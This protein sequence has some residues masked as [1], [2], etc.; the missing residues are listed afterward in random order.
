MLKIENIQDIHGFGTPLCLRCVGVQSLK[1]YDFEANFTLKHSMDLFQQLPTYNFILVLYTIEMST[2]SSLILK[3]LPI[4][5]L[6]FASESSEI[7]SAKNVLSTEICLSC[8]NSVYFTIDLNSFINFL[9]KINFFFQN[10]WCGTA[11]LK[12][13]NSNLLKYW[14]SVATFSCYSHSFFSKSVDYSIQVSID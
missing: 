3:K 9:N 5:F 14:F 13:R 7:N 12:T 11:Q 10:H 8:W 2:D 6:L 4:R 1:K